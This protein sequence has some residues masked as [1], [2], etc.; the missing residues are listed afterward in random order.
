MTT[1]HHLARSLPYIKYLLK[2]KDNKTRL[3]ALHG[4]PPFVITDIIV[5]LYNILRGN[6]RLT[7]SQKNIIMH[8][9]APLINL[10][11]HERRKIKT[12]ARKI[13]YKQRGGFIGSLL[14]IIASVLGGLVSQA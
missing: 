6:C 2:I 11:D 8:N 3:S 5:T 12:N 4:F 9:K 14:P 10:M 13:I 7:C 1:H